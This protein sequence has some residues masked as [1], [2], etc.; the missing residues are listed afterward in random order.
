MKGHLRERPA[1]SGNWYAVLDT[2]DASTGRRKRKWH[3]LEAAGKRA[4]QIECA[5]LI[6][7]MSG[8]TYMEPNK[9][10]LAAYLDQWLASI[11]A[12][13]SPRTFERYAEIAAKYIKPVLGT[14]R[15]NKLTPPGIATAYDKIRA[16]RTKGQGD[17]SPANGP[18]LPSRIERGVKTSR[19][20]ASPALQSCRRRESPKGRTPEDDHL[21][22]HSS[23]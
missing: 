15:L 12:Q 11:K 1:G 19:A 13:V 23:R 3:S 10:T 2:R 14:V 8:G 21:Q 22:P 5:N 18:A 9:T 7:A 6:A 17:L 4:A 20:V 16:S